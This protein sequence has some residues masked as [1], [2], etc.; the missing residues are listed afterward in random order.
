MKYLK[1]F[2]ESINTENYYIVVDGDM[3]KSYVELRYGIPY[4]KIK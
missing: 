3:D 2:N 4:K 1:P